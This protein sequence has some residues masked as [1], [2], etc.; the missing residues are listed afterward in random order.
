MRAVGWGGMSRGA[1]CGVGWQGAPGAGWGWPVP[2]NNH[3]VPL[4]QLVGFRPLP[5]EG[6]GNARLPTQEGKRKMS[7]GVSLGFHRF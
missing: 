4:C 1:W 7:G 3:T 2:C 5:T 6:R